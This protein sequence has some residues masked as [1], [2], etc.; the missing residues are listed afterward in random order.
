MDD[1]DNIS[2]HI[3][4]ILFN[5]NMIKIDDIY[6]STNGFL[7]QQINMCWCRENSQHSMLDH[8][9]FNNISIDNNKIKK[10]QNVC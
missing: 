3:F 2:F 8:T 7:L 10:F 6:V 9:N 5:N 4:H 1:I